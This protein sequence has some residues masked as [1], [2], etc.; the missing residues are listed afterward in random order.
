MECKKL[1]EYYNDIDSINNVNNQW[2]FFFFN[3]YNN[4]GNSE[5]DNKN[6]AISFSYKE[7]LFD[8]PHK[9][10]WN[11]TIQDNLTIVIKF[12]YRYNKK[13]HELCHDSIEKTLKLVLYIA[14]C[15]LICIIIIEYVES[16]RLY[17]CFKD[18]NNYGSIIKDIEETVKHLYKNGIVFA[19]LHDSNILVLTG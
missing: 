1:K 7:K 19:D 13:V 18:V 15:L 11:V 6:N 5:S 16:K 3:E 8:D 4:K 17:D 2:F 14:K 12:T 10:L 9:L